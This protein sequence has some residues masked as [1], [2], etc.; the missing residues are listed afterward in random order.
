MNDERFYAY[1]FN[2][3]EKDGKLQGEHGYLAEDWCTDDI[4][5]HFH[6]SKFTQWNCCE[7]R[8]FLS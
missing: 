8:S 5:K 6:Q 2:L 7:K 3:I 4:L 1:R